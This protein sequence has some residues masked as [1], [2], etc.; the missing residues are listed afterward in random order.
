MMFL[1]MILIG[2]YRPGVLNQGTDYLGEQ[3]GRM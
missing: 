2:Q 3:L 1:V